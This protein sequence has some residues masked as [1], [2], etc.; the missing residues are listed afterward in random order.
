MFS[1]KPVRISDRDWM[2]EYFSQSVQHSSEFSFGFSYIWKNIFN[3]DVARAEQCLLLKAHYKQYP[4]YLYPLGKGDIKGIIEALAISAWQDGTPLVF[5]AVLSTQKKFLEDNFPGCFT[6]AKLDDHFDYIY[7]SKNLIALPGRK[8]HAKRNHIS[9]FKQLHP[10]WRYESI[11]R[12]NMSDVKA[13]NTTWH[14][15][16]RQ[17]MCASL[18]E[19][20]SATETALSAYFDLEFDGGLIRTQD[21]RVIAY[22]I[23]EPLNADT[24]LVHIEKALCTAPGAYSMINQ[25][26]AEH[27]C[28]QYTYVNREDDSGNPGLR[29]AK[30]S[31]C[32]TFL[33]EKYRAQTTGKP[34]R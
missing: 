9:Q 32:P 30:R 4:S 16:R 8:L 24:Y 3:I 34:L 29:Q 27:H 2:N 10:D 31:Y 21:G 17:D 28:A 7:E 26:F 19:E 25:Q 15:S 18:K 5:H 22:S 14:E 1:F 20:L 12:S 13:M 23:G 11:D 6:F 33:V